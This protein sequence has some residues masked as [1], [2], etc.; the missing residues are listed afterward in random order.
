ML[1]DT[2]NSLAWLCA[3]CA[4]SL[5]NVLLCEQNIVLM[6]NVNDH[7]KISSYTIIPRT[8]IFWL[9]FWHSTDDIIRNLINAS[10]R[11]EEET[12]TMVRRGGD[13]HWISDRFAKNR[14]PRTK[15]KYNQFWDCRISMPNRKRSRENLTCFNEEIIFSHGERTRRAIT[16]R[17]HVW[18]SNAKIWGK[19]L[20]S[21]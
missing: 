4:D 20:K 13:L 17:V 5:F 6:E 14:N 18:P 8:D 19:P 9:S 7:K 15:K 12:T 1:N 11:R 10:T 2:Q 21:H 3:F 16:V